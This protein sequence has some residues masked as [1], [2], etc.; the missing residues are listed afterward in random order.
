MNDDRLQG[1]WKRL[2][3]NVR[4]QWGKLTDDDVEQVKGKKDNLIGKIQEKYGV[5]KE[6]AS[7]QVNDFFDRFDED[8]DNDNAA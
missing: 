3:G 5:V 2:K 8:R 7:R 6:E 4:E 1:K